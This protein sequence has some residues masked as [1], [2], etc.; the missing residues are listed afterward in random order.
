M[1]LGDDLAAVLG[2]CG[3][4]CEMDDA[5]LLTSGPVTSE[6]GPFRVFLAVDGNVVKAMA[7][8]TATS[9]GVRP[10]RVPLAARTAVARAL[11]AL[12]SELPEGVAEIDLRDGELRFR[13][14]FVIVP[15]MDV[16]PLARHAARLCQVFFV[17]VQIAMVAVVDA[18]ARAPRGVPDVELESLA[19][20][21]AADAV[22]RLAE[23]A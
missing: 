13:A 15:E 3:L 20:S 1:D 12:N 17:S 4:S 9:A 21:C 6:A 10:W 8:P 19:R 18:A 14:S 22:K 7:A 11:A 2:E 5:G 16:L 23:M